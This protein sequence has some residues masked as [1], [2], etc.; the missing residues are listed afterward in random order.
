MRLMVKSQ[1]NAAHCGD[2]IAFVKV[3]MDAF[4]TEKSPQPITNCRRCILLPK[5]L[6]SSLIK[7]V[8]VAANLPHQLA[9]LLERDVVLAGRSSQHYRAR[10]TG[11]VGR[12]LLR[13]FRFAMPTQRSS[14]EP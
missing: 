12:S 7:L 10:P 8:A 2:Q 13:F 4:T 11:A 14:I 5:D 6:C 9:G 1:R 3:M